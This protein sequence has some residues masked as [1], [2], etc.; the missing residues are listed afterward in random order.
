M[1]QSET[2]DRRKQMNRLNVVVL[3]M[4]AVLIHGEELSA[5]SAGP[6]AAFLEPLEAGEP[7]VFR[8][9]TVVP[10]YSRSLASLDQRLNC[11]T[12][13]QALEAGWLEIREKNGG[14]V[15][16]VVISNRSKRSIFL[17]GG[18][19]LSGC[20]QD[21]IVARDV[22]I[23]PRRS[24]LPVPVF[25]VEAGRWHHV[26]GEFKSEKNLG[27]YIL[28]G[29]AQSLAPNAQAKIWSKVSEGNRK[30]GV[31]SDTDA[32]QDAFREREVADLA[33]ELQEKLKG[34][35]R[36]EQDTVGVVI[37]L[38]DRVVGVDLFSDP[39]LFQAL[40]PKIVKACTLFVSDP[41]V[42]GTLSAEKAG[43]C[44]RALAWTSYR[45][46]RAV[47]LG[48]EHVGELSD[49]AVT[50]LGYGERLLHLSAFP[51]QDGP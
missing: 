6:V 39:E 19:I 10:V 4:L 24:R 27:T 20:R 37:G 1:L 48:V 2:F 12:L 45:E 25:C 30:L 11:A 47:D 21:R 15:P 46:R 31:I 44:L 32:Y 40:W 28:R 14:E 23:A 3:A 13:D 9:L 26:S 7:V 5:Q 51:R 38:G 8:S 22:L 35:P 50:A 42:R 49:L 33:S 43:E 18:E 17:M 36:L 41:A 16:W 29:T 34:L